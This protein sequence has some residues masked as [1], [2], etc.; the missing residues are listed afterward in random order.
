MRKLLIFLFLI[1]ICNEAYAGDIAIFDPNSQPVPNQVKQYLRSVN[2]PYYYGRDDIVIMPTMPHYN[3]KFL[4]VK[5]GQVV[6][7]TQAEKDA[8]IQAEQQAQHDA[9]VQNVN[10][11]GVTVKDMIVAF[12]KVYNSKVPPQYRIT[13]QEIIDQIKQDLGL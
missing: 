6:E 10:N 13:K 7:M 5:N 8:I 4:K 3:L 12:V 11:L 2:T 1:C 9:Q